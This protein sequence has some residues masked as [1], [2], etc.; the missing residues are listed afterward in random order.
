MKTDTGDLTLCNK[1]QRSLHACSSHFSS[2]A[3][4]RRQS[5]IFLIIMMLRL[6]VRFTAVNGMDLH[7]CTL[8]C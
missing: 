1:A 5:A 4:S 3:V 2:S 6:W 7:V 8:S